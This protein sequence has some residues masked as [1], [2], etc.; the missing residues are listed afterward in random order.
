M[1][2]PNLFEIATK[3]LSQDGFFTWL[4]DWAHPDCAQYNLELHKAGQG[5]VRLLL[6]KPD[7]FEITDVQSRRQHLNIDVWVKVNHDTVIVIED[8]TGSGQHSDQLARYR[9]DA[10]DDSPDC[11]VVCVYLKTGNESQ[12][13]LKGVTSQ[14]YR[15]IDRQRLLTFFGGHTTQSDIYNDFVDKWTAFDNCVKRYR[16]LPIGKWGNDQLE[17]FYQ[18]LEE[19][20]DNVVGWGYVSNH[21]GGFVGLWWYWLAWK[22]KFSVYLQL[23]DGK[24]CFKL[25]PYIKYPDEEVKAAQVELWS[26]LKKMAEIEGRKEIQRPSRLRVGTWMTCGIIKREDWMGA[27][28]DT[29]DEEKVVA[30]LKE[31]EAFLDRCVTQGSPK[32]S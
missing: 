27:D 16:T 7:D 20:L 11:K 8:K 17:G 9:E 32:L 1:N 24:L 22:E 2:K 21:S 18:M 3:E 25:E 6:D 19:R 31:Y 14:G 12:A 23:E 4:I 5:F 15:V 28:T 13:S 10:Q 26:V 30:K 29:L